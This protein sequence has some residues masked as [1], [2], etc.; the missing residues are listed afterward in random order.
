M[1]LWTKGNVERIAARSS[2]AAIKIVDR[3]EHKAVDPPEAPDAKAWG[4]YL[5]DEH[6]SRVQ[7]G[8]YG[9]SAGIQTVALK[10]RTL[11]T[12]TDVGAERL[13]RLALKQLPEEVPT[14]E[15]RF[16][17][18]QEKGDFDNIIKLAFIAD[19]LRPNRPDVPRGETPPLI[20]QILD[21]AVEGKFWSARPGDDEE[22]Y[23][24]ERFFPTAYVV[25]VL[26]RYE[27]ARAHAVYRE[28]R[29]WLADRLRNDQQ[30]DTP[31]NNALTGLALLDPHESHTAR[32][33]GIVDALALVQRRL[34]TWGSAEREIV[35]DRPVFY[36]FSMRSRNDYGFLHPELLAALFLLRRG[37][38]P[39]GRAFVLRVMRAL[40]DNVDRRGGFVGQNGVMST[41]DQL[42]AMRV[43]TAFR[44]AYD[45]DRLQVTPVRDQRALVQTPRSRFMA[46]IVIVLLA[47]GIVMVTADPFWPGVG[48]IVAGVLLAVAPILIADG[49]D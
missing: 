33:Q 11:D 31:S 7:W 21:R 49:D 6:H 14:S 27:H 28:A 13:V 32:P 22:R 30:L 16:A 26:Q 43:I 29:T 1:D 42:W 48:A 39:A 45:A 17:K 18:K 3:L 9:T 38:P 2:T 41:V 25:L 5:D 8:I 36:G 19:A 12:N 46:F 40:T 24:K 37:S 4:Q 20:D 44:E 10:L 15:A 23:S 47:V 35:I 34:I